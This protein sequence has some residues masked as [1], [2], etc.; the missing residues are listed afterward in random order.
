MFV[1]PDQV[2]KSVQDAKRNFVNT[3]VFDENIKKSLH[4]YI[5]T[6]EQY[7]KE[8]TKNTFD[9]TTAVIKVNPFAS[10]NK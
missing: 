4:S 3:F 7:T 2:I 5:D 10:A 6:Q 8:L 1:T 9:I